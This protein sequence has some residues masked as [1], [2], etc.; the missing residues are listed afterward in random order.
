[1]LDA[2]IARANRDGLEVALMLYQSFPAWTHPSAP[3]DPARDPASGGRGYPELGQS[4]LANE[5][6]LPDDLTSEGPWAWL[7]GY[8]CARYADTDG[9]ATPGP[10]RGGAEAGNPQARGSTGCSR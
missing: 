2:Q 3:L 7:V 6:R 4:G 5:A 10:G 1:M 9:A 8:L